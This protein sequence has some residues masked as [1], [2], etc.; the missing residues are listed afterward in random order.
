MIWSW[1]ID[2]MHLTLSDGNKSFIPDAKCIYS[3]LKSTADVQT[4]EAISCRNVV[5]SL[6]EIR[7]SKFGS[8]IQCRFYSDSCKIY[9]SVFVERSQK[10][11]PLSFLNARIIDH[12]VCDGEWFYITG[13]ISSL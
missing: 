12:C 2:G 5:L 8:A 6:P 4:I 9:C 7:F 13:D 1:K 11:I 10:Q 3:M